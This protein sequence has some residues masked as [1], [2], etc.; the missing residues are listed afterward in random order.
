MGLRLKMKENFQ[1]L[2]ATLYCAYKRNTKAPYEFQ[3]P[4]LHI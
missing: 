2:S 4:E 3:L 1:Q